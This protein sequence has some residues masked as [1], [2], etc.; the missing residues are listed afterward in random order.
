MSA[1]QIGIRGAGGDGKGS[2]SGGGT[3]SEAPD[4]LRS[5]QYGRVIDLVSE[6]EIVGLVD[7]LASIYLDDTP[8]RSGDGTI[9]FKGVAF[10][11]VPGTQSQSYLPGFAAIE[12]E[13]A[14][15][16]EVKLATPVTRSISNVNADAVRVTVS[17]PQLEVQDPTTANVTGTNVIVAIDVQTGGGGWVAQRISLI[18]EA[19]DLSVASDQ[20]VGNLPSTNISLS[21]KAVFS[22]QFHDP[23]ITWHP[24][25]VSYTVQYRAVGAGSWITLE[26]VTLVIPD[27]AW[28]FNESTPVTAEVVRTHAVT[29]LAEDEYEM[30]VTAITYGGDDP[31]TLTVTGGTIVTRPWW[32]RISGKAS[33]KYQ[34]AYRIELPGDG[35]WDIRVRRLTADSTS[36]LLRNAT[37]W[38]S[39]TEIIDAKLTYPN[40]AL[41]AMT[42]DA[43][44]FRAIPRRGYDIKGLKV[45][46]PS[47]YDPLARTY[48]G[49]WDGTFQVAWTDNPAWCFYDLLTNERYGLGAFLDEAQIDKWG[50]Y[51]I[52]QY[53]DEGVANGYGATEPRFT[54]NLY[55]QTREEA[56]RV[57]NSMASIFRGMVYWSAGAVVAAQDAPQVVA[58]IFAPAK[59]IGGQFHYQGSAAKARHTV[60]LV[61][62]NDPS[63]RY[64]QKIEYVEDAAGI[65]RYGVIQ[66]ELLAVGC[67]SRG[68]AHRLGRWLLYSERM[69]IE[70]V[71]FRA[72]LEGLVVGPGDVIQTTDPIRAGRR[73]GGRLAA[74][75]VSSV[76]LDSAVTIEA[77]KTYTLW[78][79]LPD[80]TVESRVATAA[81]GDRT[82]LAVAPDFSAV[83]QAWAVW[84]L[85]ANDLQPESWR[86]VSVAEVDDTQAE[87]VA[88]AYR[89]DKYAAVEANLVLEP[90]AVSDLGSR[91][92][93]PTA[94]VMAES[95]YLAAVSVVGVKASL[96]WQG[97]AVR[98]AVQWRLADQNWNKIETVEQFADLQ[99][100]AEGLHE[101]RV[102]SIN[103]L[104]LRSAT[105]ATLSAEI[106]GKVLLPADVAGFSVV[107]S[108]GFG[109]ASWVL[110]SDLDVRV[111]GRIVVRHSPL[112]TGATWENGVIV[113][114]FDGNAVSGIVPLM[115]GTYLAKALDSSGNWSASAASFVASEGMVTGWTTV[116]SSVQHSAF[117]GAKSN[118][119]LVGSGIRLTGATLI[120][121]IALLIDSWPRI[122]S[123]GGIAATGSYE[124]D[125]ALDL[126]TVATRRFEADI[127]ATSFDDGFKLD[128]IETLMDDWGP[129][130]GDAVNDCDVT[131]YASVTN[132]NPAGSPAWGAWTP[133]FVADFSCRAAR[134]KLEFA[135][136]NPQHNIEVT[137]LRV[138]VKEPA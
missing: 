114:E 8:V 137:T 118:I 84:V 13:Q 65:A 98:Y 99:P 6:G 138:D 24:G 77:G 62:W 134:F 117:L 82:V 78:A 39:Y 14:V 31:C 40:S 109:L 25:A 50:L 9:N 69:E 42:V 111:G 1:R 133:F 45:R 59:V 131:L 123:L 107:K 17:V 41:I 16:A 36:Q 103:A 122:D 53:C 97:N 52:A 92:D 91:P 37:W 113:E 57:V 20:V 28:I 22:P 90:L 74:A 125:A 3:P 110:A 15:S 76:T 34:R 128:A 71:T 4:S 94:L 47:N 81:P 102:W 49:A 116:G 64:R 72:G 126:A 132:D 5:R 66:T 55:L 32:D 106:F 100:M 23:M 70:T 89:P 60:A 27:G 86:V 79:V 115:T 121:D 43:E 95:L 136:G 2:A 63:D 127:A 26:N 19:F 88:L 96:S 35:P 67:T 46:I 124:F 112:T 18:E 130:D 12:A 83:P 73:M 30:R 61:A 21:V 29:G 10:A 135:S 105:P 104:G 80:G 85:A 75:T 93:A 119:T 33:A 101:F 120:D 51:S 129:L 38:D 68:Q 7:G 58:D 48:S 11:A 108:A 44:Q 56:Y 54:C 87:I